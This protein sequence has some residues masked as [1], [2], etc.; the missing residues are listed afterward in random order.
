MRD[1]PRQDALSAMRA[2]L[3]VS[4]SERRCCAQFLI[5]I[6]AFATRGVNQARCTIFPLQYNKPTVVNDQF[7]NPSWF[8]VRKYFLKKQNNQDNN[9]TL[10]RLWTVRWAV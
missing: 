5:Q 9:Y 4:A 1:V 10:E 2:G 3:P 7:L 8:L 6:S